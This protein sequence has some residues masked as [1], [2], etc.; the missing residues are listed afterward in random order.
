MHP[1]PQCGYWKCR[2]SVAGV[3]I[4]KP[5]AIWLDKSGAM[6]GSIGDSRQLDLDRLWQRCGANPVSYETYKY[7]YEHG[8]FPGEI[9]T[10]A[11]RLDNYANDPGAK[12]RDEIIQ[13]IGKVDLYLNKLPDPLTDDAA[14]SLANYLDMIRAA[15]AMAGKVLNTEIAEQKAEIARRRVLW[16]APID[17]AADLAKRLRDV[18]TPFLSTKKASGQ[19]AKLGGQAGKRIGLRKVWVAHVTDWDMVMTEFH[20]DSD[21]RA[22]IQKLL[23]ARARSKDRE[24]LA[25]QGCIFHEKETA[26]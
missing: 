15:E 22:L 9:D 4:W 24:G 1:N 18:L 10:I 20:T 25:I 14:H 16:S 26:G 5:V 17:A 7:A 2:W 11:P 13:L 3:R 21:V 12:L 23:D 6:I 19:E 8:H